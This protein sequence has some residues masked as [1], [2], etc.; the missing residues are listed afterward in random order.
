MTLCA[1]KLKMRCAHKLHAAAVCAKLKAMYKLTAIYLYQSQSIVSFIQ[2]PLS[3]PISL[4][5]N[6]MLLFQLIR[7]LPNGFLALKMEAICY[8][9][10]LVSTSKSAR[11]YNPEDHHRNLYCRENLK[12]SLLKQFYQQLFC[13]HF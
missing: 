8:S 2:L 7:R 13:T 1:K 5:T 6:L 10:M 12:K 3:Q 9:E 4:R 11:R